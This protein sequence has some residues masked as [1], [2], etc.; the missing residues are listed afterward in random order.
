MVVMDYLKK[1]NKKF[2]KS[3]QWLKKRKEILER[4][5]FECQMC[6][7]RGLYSSAYAVHHIRHYQSNPELAL[8]DDNLL[9]LCAECHNEVHPEKIRSMINKNSKR[10]FKNIEQ[11]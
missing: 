11:W 4:D 1:Y 7:E 9:S 10:K 2:Y 3:S 5:N 6:K 8:T